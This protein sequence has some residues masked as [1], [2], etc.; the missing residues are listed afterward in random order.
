MVFSWRKKKPRS[1]NGDKKKELEIPRHFLCPITLDL[2]KDPVTLSSGIT[3]D[4]ES[5]EKW[6]DDGNF[7]CPVSN[8]VLRSFD[9]IPNHSLRK[10]IQ[11]W[12]VENRS[13]G[14]ERIPTPRIPVRSAEVSEVLF[15]IMDS[16]RQLDRCACLDSLH[17]LKKWGLESE[18]NKRCIVANAAASGAIAAGFDAFAGESI[19]KNINVLE[20]I[21]FVINW[22]FPLTEQAQRYIGSQ[23]SLYCIALFLK[24]KDL[25]LKQNAITVLA[26]LLSCNQKY[27]QELTTIDGINKTLFHFINNPIC[28]SIT[29]PSLTLIYHMVSLSN[30]NTTTEF[31]N[32]GLTPLLLEIMIDSQKAICEKALAII[33]Q[34]CETAQGRGF[35]YDDALAMPVLVKKILRVSELA[36]EYSVSAIWK[37]SKGDEKALMEA[38]QFGAFQKLLLLIQV[39]CNDKT[40]EK[41][42]ELLKLL[43]P[44]RPGLECI[45]SLD[46]K[47]IKRSF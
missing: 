8:Q 4:R 25:S 32:M 46:F 37:L 21:L 33:D 34:L 7:T 11:D 17:K 12:C 31:I 14:V 42:T 29:K 3:Y 38:L 40:K 26:E 13:Y 36:T 43:N 20:E 27:A 5:I 41:A 22:M 9:Q 1:F 39:G 23:A 35:A 24:S 47:N 18:R 6:L 19:D 30:E 15:S 44:Y 16:T 10:M 45:D 28:P 2:L